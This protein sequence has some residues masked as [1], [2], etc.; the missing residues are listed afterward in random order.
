MAT[1][2]TSLKPTPQQ[3]VFLPKV[4]RPLTVDANQGTELRAKI[5]EE[6][7]VRDSFGGLTSG[8]LVGLPGERFGKPFRDGSEMR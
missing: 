7:A 3:P 2:K 8:G 5:R 4:S 1:Q 6:L